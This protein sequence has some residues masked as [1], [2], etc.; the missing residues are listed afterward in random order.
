MSPSLTEGPGKQ[1]MIPK[2]IYDKER[3][4][5]IVCGYSNA[6]KGLLRTPTMAQRSWPRGAEG[7]M[8]GQGLRH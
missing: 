3:K 2:P 5:L 7:E 6:Q 8:Y 1:W 4:G